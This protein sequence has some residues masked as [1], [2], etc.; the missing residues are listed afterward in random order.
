MKTKSNINSDITF[1]AE[2]FISEKV[3]RRIFLSDYLVFPFSFL[4]AIIS[5]S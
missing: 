2:P 4:I 3:G 5:F 1:A